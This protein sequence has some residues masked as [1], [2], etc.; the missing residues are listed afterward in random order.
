MAPRGPPEAGP[1]TDLR[2]IFDFERLHPAGQVFLESL[3]EVAPY[4]CGQ[5][6][7]NK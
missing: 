2:D 1:Y 6:R 5:V 4:D 3:C 7:V